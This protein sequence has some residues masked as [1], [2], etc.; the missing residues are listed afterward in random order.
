MDGY[1]QNQILLK[2]GFYVRI[3]LDMV[4]KKTPSLMLKV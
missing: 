4:F 2:Q 3:K 1:S